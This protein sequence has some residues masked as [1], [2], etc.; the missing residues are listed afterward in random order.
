MADTVVIEPT[1][2]ATLEDVLAFAADAMHA[3]EGAHPSTVYLR[4]PLRLHLERE[5]LTDRSVVFNIV[6]TFIR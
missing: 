6:P 4:S 1:E 3:V 2:C 5:T